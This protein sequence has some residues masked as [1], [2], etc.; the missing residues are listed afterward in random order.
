MKSLCC[1]S[2]CI[3]NIG[4][5]L[6]LSFVLS[7][8]QNQF[9]MYYHINM[10][11]VFNDEQK[12][13]T[14]ESVYISKTDNTTSKHE[15]YYDEKYLQFQQPL[16][17]FG[18]AYKSAYLNTLIP[19]NANN[20]LEIGCSAGYILGNVNGKNKFCVEINDAAITIA[21]NENQIEHISKD[22]KTIDA[23]MDFIY[24]TSVLEHIPNPSAI[25]QDAHPI[26]SD[27]GVMINEV[28][29]EQK[30]NKYTE[31]DINKHLYTWSELL[32]G[33]LITFSGGTLCE[34]VQWYEMWAHTNYDKM[35]SDK[36]SF[37]KVSQV[38]GNRNQWS[39]VMCLS[40]S[41]NNNNCPPPGFLQNIT[42]C[43][44]AL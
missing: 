24:T 25:L 39:H 37:C 18:G 43:N 32:L 22:I 3:I 16:N 27:N 29:H 44:W 9:Y 36:H 31:N 1:N 4:T 33:N 6:L 42:N 10:S 7:T 15:N 34:C 35:T 26:L 13:T 21:K 5:I 40:T 12:N 19:E 17:I 14:I 2:K 41:I 30:N 8:L 28:I 20:V 11:E 38:H 23:K